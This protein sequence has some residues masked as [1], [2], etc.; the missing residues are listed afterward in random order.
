MRRIIGWITSV[1]MMAQTSASLHS[2][3]SHHHTKT[4]PAIVYHIQP[5]D[6]LQ[7]I[8]KRFKTSVATLERLNPIKNP[9]LI[10]AGQILRIP[11]T[12]PF[13]PPGTKAIVSTLT[14]YTDGYS[15]TG[16]LP[17]SQ[18]FGVT[19]T[20][21]TTIQGIT[22]AVDPNVI[23]Y[24]T[25]LYIPGVGFRIAD[26]TGGAITGTHI[27]V[28]YQ[29]EATALQFGRKKNQI[30]Y[31][32]PY[33]MRLMMK[34]IIQANE[35]VH[36]AFHAYNKRIIQRKDAPLKR[37]AHNDNL[38]LL[39]LRSRH[40]IFAAHS[41]RPATGFGILDAPDIALMQSIW[42]PVFAVAKRVL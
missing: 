24:G 37:A 33:S 40:A 16:K 39:L 8:A 1:A 11:Q 10:Q 26:D 15:S 25:V 20:G 7:I 5:G 34:G 13:A 18:A 23:P 41:K 4:A 14:A 9:D 31:I 30:V 21:D 27:D 32:L 22:A 29:N 19:A 38:Q 35:H 12:L 6:T 28:F 2:S 17:G 42:R 36:T 3:P